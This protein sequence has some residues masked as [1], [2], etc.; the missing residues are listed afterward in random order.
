[1]SDKRKPEGGAPKPKREEPLRDL[2]AAPESDAQDRV[3]GGR[4][5]AAPSPIPIPYPN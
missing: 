4:S 1:M 5:P 2:P 3:R